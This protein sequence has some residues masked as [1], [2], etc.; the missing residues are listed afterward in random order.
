MGLVHQLIK[1]ICHKAMMVNGVPRTNIPYTYTCAAQGAKYSFRHGLILTAGIV[2]I[3]ETHLCP[4][5]G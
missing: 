4:V 2:Q 5:K 3:E 1:R